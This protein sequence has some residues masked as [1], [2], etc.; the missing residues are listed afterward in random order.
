[1]RNVDSQDVVFLSLELSNSEEFGLLM[2]TVKLYH[3]NA[4][5]RSPGARLIRSILIAWKYERSHG[6]NSVIGSCTRAHVHTG[7]VALTG[8]NGKIPN[9]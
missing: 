8:F 2:K 5:D 4:A 6:E 9:Y 7:L 3:D 1:M